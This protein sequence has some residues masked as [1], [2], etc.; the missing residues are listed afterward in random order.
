VS[1][2]L[3]LGTSWRWRFIK[4]DKIREHEMG[5]GHVVHMGEIRKI[6]IKF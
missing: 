3:D 6:K 4:G 1:R 2:I 5:Q